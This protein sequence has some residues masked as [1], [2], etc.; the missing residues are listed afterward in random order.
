LSIDASTIIFD[1]DGKKK[2]K[3]K[4]SSF[5]PFSPFV[6]HLLTV[7]NVM[8]DNWEHLTKTYGSGFLITRFVSAVVSPV[9]L[10]KTLFN[11]LCPIGTG[12]SL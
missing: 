3:Q 6:Y 7:L 8:Q 2:I 12:V 1:F 9:R 11:L 4:L 10:I 5:K